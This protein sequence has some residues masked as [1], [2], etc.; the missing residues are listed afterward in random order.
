MYTTQL[1]TV[2]SLICLGPLFQKMTH[3]FLLHGSLWPTNLEK[4]LKPCYPQSAPDLRPSS[5]SFV[6]ERSFSFAT[7]SDEVQFRNNSRYA[8]T[9]IG[10]PAHGPRVNFMPNQTLLGRDDESNNLRAQIAVMQA[11]L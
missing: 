3:H 7:P 5:P 6:P 1:S 4:N 10:E 9:C 8:R 2:F 11:S